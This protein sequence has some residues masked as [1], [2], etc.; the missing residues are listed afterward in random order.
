MA[1]RATRPALATRSPH[2][3]ARPTRPQSAR[4]RRRHLHPS[5]RRHLHPSRRRHLRRSRHDVTWVAAV[6]RH[7]REQPSTSP[8]PQPSTPGSGVPTTLPTQPSPTF[9]CVTGP[10]GS[11]LQPGAGLPVPQTWTPTPPGWVTSGVIGGC[12]AE[13]TRNCR[14]GPQR[15]ASRWS[16][17]G[18]GRCS[19]VASDA[20][21]AGR[22]LRALPPINR[23]AGTSG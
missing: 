21:R 22:L 17:A 16:R 3:S 4:S 19:P 13:F 6:R 18:N 20:P 7:L 14:R 10:G 8:A 15:C 1:R 9:V 11:C 12:I 5:R 23:E 2:G